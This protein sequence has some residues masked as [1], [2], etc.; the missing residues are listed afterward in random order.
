[1]WQEVRRDGVND[2]DAQLAGHRVAGGLGDFFQLDSL[3][4]HPSRLGDN[5]LTQRGDAHI[6]GAALE[7]RH[8]NLALNFFKATDS[9]GWLTWQA[10][11]ALPKCRSRARATT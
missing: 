2:A 1:L 8:A 6:T 9:V 4:Q 5:T 10:S 7:E 3:F 11:A